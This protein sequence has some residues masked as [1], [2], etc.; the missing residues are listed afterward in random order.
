M[1]PKIRF[2]NIFQELANDNILLPSGKTGKIRVISYINGIKQ[3]DCIENFAA[4]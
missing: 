1:I 3:T 2:E 4:F